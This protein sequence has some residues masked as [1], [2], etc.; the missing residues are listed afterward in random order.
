MKFEKNKK[1]LLQILTLAGKQSFLYLRNLTWFEVNI[2]WKVEKK[3]KKNEKQISASKHEN[4]EA[5]K[6]RREIR[7]D[8]AKTANDKNTDKEGQSYEAGVF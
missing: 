6:K 5:T 3:K 2:V 8:K 7:R 4:L 1:F